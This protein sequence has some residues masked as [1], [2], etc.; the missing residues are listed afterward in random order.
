MFRYYRVSY[1]IRQC[2]ISQ[3][4]I[5]GAFMKIKRKLTKTSVYKV[6]IINQV[7]LI[8]ALCCLN[9]KDTQKQKQILQLCGF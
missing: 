3:T 5:Y 7:Q 9:E 6:P 8:Y 1:N 4:E 2:F